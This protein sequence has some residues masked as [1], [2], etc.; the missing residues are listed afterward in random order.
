MDTPKPIINLNYTQNYI[1][2]RCSAD[3]NP[4]AMIVWLKGRSEIVHIGE[5]LDLN[6][7]LSGTDYLYSRVYGEYTCRAKSTGHKDLDFTTNIITNGM[8]A[9]TGE[10]VYFAEKD[11][12]LNIKFSILSSPEL[13]V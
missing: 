3:S 10:S 13:K 8:P 5:Y 12:N 4:P 11:K 1:S 2:L 6:T 9:I 7:Q